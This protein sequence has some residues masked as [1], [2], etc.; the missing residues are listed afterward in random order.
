MRIQLAAFFFL[1]M[2]PAFAD[3]QIIPQVADGAGWST[4]IVLSNKTATA[5]TVALSFNRQSPTG[6]SNTSLWTPPFVEGVNQSSVSLP[7][8][9]TLFLHTPGTSP[10]LTQ[11]WGQIDAAAGVSGYAIF[12]ANTNTARAQD[13]TATAGTASNR[14]LAPFD[15]SSGYVSA[16]A[17][18][19]P[20]N[21]PET[22]LLTVRTAD[23]T[24]N[25]Q[26][27]LP[28]KGQSTFLMATLFGGTAGK[29]GLAEFY[30]ASGSISIIALRANPSGAF[31]AAPVYVQTG[32]QIIGAPL[33]QQ[34][35][36]P[37]TQ[38][39]PQVADGGGWSTTIVLANTTTGD[40]PVQLNFKK[41]GAGG[42]T[43]QWN[44]T[45]QDPVPLT[46]PA[47][48][49]RFLRTPGNS[50][51]PLSQGW[52]ELV[53][54]PRIVGYAIFTSQSGA[55]P[56]QDSTAPAVS[57]SSR[58]LAPFDNTTG[59]VTAIALVNPTAS[60]E[61][62]S[63]NFRFSDASTGTATVTV[64]A[65]GQV[66]FLMPNQFAA[67]TGK[68]GLAEFYVSSGTISIIALRGN[69]SGAITS[70]P[71]FFETGAPIITTGGGGGG[72]GGNGGGGGGGGST[73]G[74][75]PTQSEIDSWI[76]RGNYSGGSIM[77]TRITSYAYDLVTGAAQPVA[78]VDTVGGTFQRFSGSDLGKVLRGEV[79][80]NFPS[81]TP[82]PGS[83]V[84]YN[85]SSV[86]ANPYPNFIS[87]GLDAGPQFTSSGPNG[88]QT[89]PKSGTKGNYNAG[90][91]PNTYLATGNY[92]INGPGGPDVGAFS[93]SFD[94]VPDFIVTNPDDMKATINRAGGLTVRWSGGESSSVLTITGSSGG[95][96]L[97][98]GA[99]EGAAF[100]CIQNVSAGSFTVPASVL[101][102]VPASTAINVG[103]FNFVIRGTLSVTAGG[104]GARFTAPSGLDILTA[105]NFWSWTFSPQYQ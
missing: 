38:V 43:S 21:N 56:A 27:D 70:A 44:L 55:S 91:I 100:V 97:Q 57:A 74:T 64:P 58:I 72:G 41:A 34:T 67:T 42:A 103:G 104:K 32:N 79:P 24:S 28:P 77:L 61:I 66:T 7:A 81:L 45:F 26:I 20:T 39:I 14:I 68:S 47:G 53:A 83:C 8:G 52:A 51:V 86:T 15:N 95:A 75:S 31:T 78:K 25:G 63:V 62:V 49:A 60:Q 85:I 101:T 17:V 80:P 88:T 69:P 93:G 102:Q 33:S 65:Q 54:D 105:N 36:N 76:S 59:F 50:G 19:N 87:T 30:V 22:V 71:V 98:T 40:L 5:Q 92:A 37:Q 46:I 11:G 82:T 99:V 10:D 23:G 96:N 48:S 4:T 1:G 89:A 13:A 73:P 6:S 29:S 9:S 94:I 90:N 35:P 3:T 16:F 2:L 18:A 12:T 84:V